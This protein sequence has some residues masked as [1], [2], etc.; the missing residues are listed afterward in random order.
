MAKFHGFIGFSTIVETAPGVHQEQITER[1]YTGD[2]LRTSQTW[3][4]AEKVNDDLKLDVRVSIVADPFAFANMS[5]IKYVKWNGVSW[6][7]SSIDHER[8]RLILKVGGVYNG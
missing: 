5:T 2:F 8:P 7:V 3:S 1:E 6:R 4:T